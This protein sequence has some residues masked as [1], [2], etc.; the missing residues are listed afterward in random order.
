MELIPGKK[1]R[2]QKHEL[3]ASDSIRRSTVRSEP[4]QRRN[5]LESTLFDDDYKAS[6]RAYCD[7]DR[8][9]IPKPWAVPLPN[10][11]GDPTN[12]TPFIIRDVLI[13][14]QWHLKFHWLTPRAQR[15][16]FGCRNTAMK[17]IAE[18]KDEEHRLLLVDHYQDLRSL[19]R[20]SPLTRPQMPV[21]IIAVLNLK[22]FRYLAEYGEYLAEEHAPLRKRLAISS[23]QGIDT[24]T[25]DKTWTVVQQELDRYHAECR[26]R[27]KRVMGYNFKLPECTTYDA[28]LAV[29]HELGINTSHM[30]D[31]I[32][33]YT[34]PERNSPVPS[35]RKLDWETLSIQRIVDINA[36]SISILIKECEWGL[37]ASQLRLDLLD[38]PHVFDL[39]DQRPFMEA[40]ESVRDRYFKDLGTLKPNP[41][42]EARRLTQQKRERESIERK[43]DLMKTEVGREALRKV[44]ADNAWL[45][46]SSDADSESDWD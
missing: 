45:S 37:L 26:R 15:I 38:A 13:Y 14:A 18:P 39:R 35:F 29:G 30:R 40:V 34:K 10:D 36:V 31:T 17:S 46:D 25:G 22:R 1:H 42:L 16:L 21:E 3:L 2:P 32:K 12:L 7:M 6:V 9:T 24:F 44:Y 27:M 11:L 28:L 20:L 43:K 41:S 33:W 8:L 19:L 5:S 23:S 4:L